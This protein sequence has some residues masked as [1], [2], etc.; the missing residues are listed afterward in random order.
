[1]DATRAVDGSFVMLK[2]ILRPDHP[3][4]AEI[5]SFLGSGT[6][7][8]DPRNHCVPIYEV[9][10]VPNDPNRVIIVMPFLR[11]FDEP[12]M[13]TVQEAVEFFGQI[14]EVRIERV[15]FQRS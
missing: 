9:M 10:A 1:M 7:A 14:F 3:F 5:A 12:P 6:L 11:P 15:W 8:E 4:E 2:L 13:Q